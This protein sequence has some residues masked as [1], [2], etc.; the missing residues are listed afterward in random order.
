MSTPTFQFKHANRFLPHILLVGIGIGTANYIVNENLNWIQWIIQSISTSVIIGYTLVVVGTNRMWLEY[1]IKANTRLLILAFFIFFLAGLFATEIEHF[2]R[3]QVFHNQEFAPFSA[4]KMYLFN[5]IISL[6]LGY[7]FFLSDFSKRKTLK[8][9]KSQNDLPNTGIPGE[10]NLESGTITNIPVKQ[11]E[12]ILLLPIKEIV[13]FEAFDN[14]S[15]VFNSLGEKK[16]CD[17]SLLFLEKR[18]GKNFSRIH[19]KYI[20]NENYIKQ[21]K[22]HLN[23]RYRIFFNIGI[24]PISSSK[25]YLA[26]IKKLIKIQ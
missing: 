16:L 13:Y 7:S 15:F 10:K 20:V 19:R 26:S 14:Y 9:T 4:G 17:Y 25:G 8:S 1:H 6:I 5:G 11:G 18:L 2:I 21:I 12:N 22:P 24:D 3:S 23:G